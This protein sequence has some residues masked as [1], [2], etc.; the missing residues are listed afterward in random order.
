MCTRSYHSNIVYFYIKIKFTL[1]KLIFILIRFFRVKLFYFVTDVLSETNC[2]LFFNNT[3]P[4]QW[5]MLSAVF[6]IQ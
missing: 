4:L 5:Y 2:K 1:K 3:L 6:I